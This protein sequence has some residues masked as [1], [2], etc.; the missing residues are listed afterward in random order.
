MG[1]SEISGTHEPGAHYDRVHRAWRLI[2][3][4]EF[5]Y[6]YFATP[7][8]PL[9]VATAALTQKMLDLAHIGQGDRVLDIG[10]GTGRQSCDLAAARILTVTTRKAA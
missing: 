4:E 7:E 1:G 9:P 3:G 5:H 2:M 10:C 8:T 6:G